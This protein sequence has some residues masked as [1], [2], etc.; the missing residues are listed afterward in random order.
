MFFKISERVAENLREVQDR[1][2]EYTR[3]IQRD[4][5]NDKHGVSLDGLHS[6]VRFAGTP[7]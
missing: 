5:V 1:S 7:T 4:I 3:L 6:Y 2:R